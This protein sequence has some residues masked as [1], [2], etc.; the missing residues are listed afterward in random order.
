MTTLCV[1]KT[2]SP[3]LHECWIVITPR[4]LLT[5]AELCISASAFLKSYSPAYLRTS[6]LL[7]CSTKFTNSLQNFYPTLEMAGTNAFCIAIIFL[8]LLLPTP[9]DATAR[10]FPYS[11]P[12]TMIYGETRRPEGGYVNM[13]P[14]PLH[15]R[16]GLPYGRVVKHCMPKG[17]RH[18]SAPSRYANSYPFGLPC[19]TRNP[20]QPWTS[21]NGGGIQEWLFWSRGIYE[22][23]NIDYICAVLLLPTGIQTMYCIWFESVSEFV[24]C[25]CK[26]CA[27]R[28]ANS[29]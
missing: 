5:S 16:K 21:C 9:N 20:F 11:G 29:N 4:T 14:P 3:R 12:S 17:L 28:Y 27:L 19:F 13:K 24:V 25:A 22:L 7:F 8:L 1:L 23:G 15:H 18:S 2:E 10:N 26:L 6:S